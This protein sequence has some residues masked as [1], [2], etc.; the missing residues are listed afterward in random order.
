M[1]K[2]QIPPARNF[3]A[4]TLHKT[5]CLKQMPEKSRRGIW[6]SDKMGFEGKVPLVMEPVKMT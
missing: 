2:T 5:V 1:C 3:Q 4:V 6:P